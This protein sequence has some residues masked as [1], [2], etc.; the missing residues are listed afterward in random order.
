MTRGEGELQGGAPWEVQVAH[1]PRAS[2]AM[3]AVSEP[4]WRALWRHG[5]HPSLPGGAAP[6]RR[7]SWAGAVLEGGGGRPAPLPTRRLPDKDKSRQM[8]TVSRTPPGAEAGEK[9]NVLRY[10]CRGGSSEGARLTGI[11]F[12]GR[13]GWR[14]ER[15]GIAGI[16]FLGGVPEGAVEE[17][18]E[19]GCPALQCADSAIIGAIVVRFPL[20]AG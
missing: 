2:P 17:I 9:R 5:A 1:H 7:S 8:A 3:G 13:A 16:C 18:G 14:P 6:E 10:C 20:Q 19:G 11:S 12:L 4:L 15:R